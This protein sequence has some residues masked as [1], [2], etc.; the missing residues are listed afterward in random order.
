MKIKLLSNSNS[1]LKSYF[2]ILAIVIFFTAFLPKMFDFDNT[3]YTSIENAQVAASQEAALPAKAK[4][5][6][7]YYSRIDK[8]SVNALKTSLDDNLWI[9]L[10]STA[11]PALL[12]R[13]LG[14]NDDADPEDD[15]QD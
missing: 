8:P 1:S 11:F 14:A 7:S 6:F 10:D 15:V 2:F 9:L 3:S 5:G 13:K 4:R 12:V